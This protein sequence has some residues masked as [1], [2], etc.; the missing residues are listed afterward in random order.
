MS[1]P[2]PATRAT[3]GT[4]LRALRQTRQVRQFTPEPAVLIAD[5]K[6]DLTGLA[7]PGD[8]TNAK[9]LARAAELA[10]GF[11][12]DGHPVEFLSLSGKLGAQVRATRE[13]QAEPA[14]VVLVSNEARIDRPKGKNAARVDGLDTM[15]KFDQQALTGLQDSPR[16]R[17]CLG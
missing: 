16:V 11:K 10:W 14:A 13:A 7:L 3:A 5:I 2:S 8:A 4:V 1:D 12:P 6:G 9:V 17:S 15:I